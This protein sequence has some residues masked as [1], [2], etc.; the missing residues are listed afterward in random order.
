MRA[1]DTQPPR[2]Q[3]RCKP[4]RLRRT[5]VGAPV[6]GGVSRLG[7]GGER[8][9]SQRAPWRRGGRAAGAGATDASLT[10]A[11]HAD[12]LAATKAAQREL[13]D[14]IKA[15]ERAAKEKREA[16]EAAQRELLKEERQTHDTRRAAR[17]RRDADKRE[18]KSE[19]GQTCEHGV[20]EW[21]GGSCAR[22]RNEAVRSACDMHP[23]PPPFASRALQDLLPTRQGQ[24]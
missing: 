14:A 5:C 2:A 3:T 13:H 11:F 15:Q 7:G 20:C 16:E 23:P 9:G 21:L 24:P 1:G 8:G 19:T 17:D 10:P 18:R 12:K 6:W 22:P 4:Q